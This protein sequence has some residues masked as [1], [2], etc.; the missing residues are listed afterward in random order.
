MDDVDAVQAQ[1]ARN[2]I[3]SGDWVT[4]RLDGVAYLEKAPAVYWAMAASYAVFGVH[5]WAARIPVALAAIL[6]CW[7]VARF[8]VWAFSPEAGMFA[9]VV[10]ATCAGL[11]LFTRIL[12]PDVMLTLAITLAIW[13]FL[14]T[15]D[16]AESRPRLWACVLPASLAGAVLLKGLI[17]VLFPAGAAILYLLWTRQLFSGRTWRRLH[18]GAG[19]L[20]FLIIAAPWHVLA[21]LRN[22]PYFDFT[23]SSGPGHYHGFLWFYF[24]NEH[25][26]RFMNLRYPRDYNTVPLPLFWLLHVVWLFPWSGYVPALFRLGYRPLDRAGKARTMLLCWTG[27]VMVFFSFSTTQEYYSMPIYPA[28][29]MLLGSAIALRPASCAAMRAAAALAGV[30]ALASAAI[31]FYVRGLPAPGD[32][33]RAL[34]QNPEV[35]TLSMGHITDLTMSAFAYLRLPLTMALGAFLIGAIGGWWSRR[36]V[37]FFALA[38][39]MTLFLNAA[40]TALTVFDPY[41]SSRPLAEALNRAPRGKLIVDDQY[42]S[43]SSV[44]F[45][46]DYKALLLNGRVN[47][48]EY[49]SNA[50]DAA[51]VFITNVDIPKLWNSS[52]RWYLVADEKAIS[53]I[54]RLTGPGSVHRLAESGGKAL[55]TNLPAS[56]RLISLGITTDSITAQ[57]VRPGERRGSRPP[58]G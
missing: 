16:E 57:P 17:G 32:I 3:E 31:L 33:S 23:L 19:L 22:P 21:T 12:I 55:V 6:L 9:G 4:C 7:V 26:L 2:M 11:F 51:R 8:A 47:N 44:F 41:L 56:P 40:R 18:P 42:Y 36:R 39:M 29:A 46:T 38:V 48:L 30:C 28:L 14:R 45:Y 15:L 27:F 34:T 25:L 13:S 54:E 20:G 58:T 1:I 5:D 49:G 24:I 10:L 43:F 52:E 50:P 35:Y 53:R 37:A